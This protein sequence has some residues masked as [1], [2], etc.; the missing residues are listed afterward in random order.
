VL[1][2]ILEE[3]LRRTLIVYGDWSV[4]ISRPISIVMLL[5]TAAFLTYS[6]YE[7]IRASRGQGR[8]TVEITQ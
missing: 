4:F 2:P 8:P 6:L 7:S 5:I 3:N 1:G